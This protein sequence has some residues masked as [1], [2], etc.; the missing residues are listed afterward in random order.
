[1][2]ADM[3]SKLS[4]NYMYFI[5]NNCIHVSKYYMYIYPM[6]IHVHVHDGTIHIINS[7]VDSHTTLHFYIR[8]HVDILASGHCCRNVERLK[9]QVL[10]WIT[11][12]SL[13]LHMYKWSWSATLLDLPSYTT[14]LVAAWFAILVGLKVT[15]DQIANLAGPRSPLCTLWPGDPYLWHG[16]A[17]RDKRHASQV[18]WSTD[19]YHFMLLVWS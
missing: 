2:W 4:I 3:S 7:V 11:K 17:R 18:F 16:I 14:C 12:Q 1:M 5:Y 9:W 13:M 6:H 19:T 10:L 8:V 15:T